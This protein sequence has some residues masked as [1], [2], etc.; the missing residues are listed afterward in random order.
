M[1]VSYTSDLGDTGKFEKIQGK[2][3]VLDTIYKD[4]NGQPFS[5]FVFIPSVYTWPYDYLFKTYGKQTY[6]YEPGRQKKGLAYLISEPDNDK[7]WR[8]NGWLETVVQ[9]GKTIWIKTLLNG[10]IL[11]RRQY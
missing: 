2:R 4:A 11:E 5:V 9:G 7:P 10:L 3:F 1:Y 6:G 8:Q